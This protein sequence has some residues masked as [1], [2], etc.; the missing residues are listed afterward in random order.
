MLHMTATS[1]H[2]YTHH[3]YVIRRLMRVALALLI[4]QQLSI[5]FVS[6]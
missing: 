3:T 5:T 4:V 2:S 6:T 1:K